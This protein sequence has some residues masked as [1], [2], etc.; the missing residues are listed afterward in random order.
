LTNPKKL[1]LDMDPGI[2]DAI[3]L[4]MVSCLEDVELLGVSTVAGNVD[5]VKTTR[6]AL[7]ILEFL[8]VRVG[9]FRGSSRPLIRPHENSAHVHGADGLGGVDL[10][11]PKTGP[12]PLPGPM[13]MSQFARSEP[14]KITVVATG[15]LT[16]VAI[17][18]ML[19]TE[20]PN[21]VRQLVIMGGAFSITPYGKGNV[22]QFSE[23]NIYADPEAA[24][25]VF[26]SFPDIV[27]VGLDVTTDPR[28][29][30]R[31]PD[32]ERLVTG[33][34]RGQLAARMMGFVV[35]RMGHFAPHD[36]LAVYCFYNPNIAKYVK[37]CVNVITT[38]DS[39]RGRTVFEIPKGS[40]KPSNVSVA[41]EVDAA[42]FKEEL[43]D[44]LQK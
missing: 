42:R 20:F 34:K 21:I 8:G 18:C 35:N 17:A 13:A 23:Y 36:P 26:S 16:N 19:D 1:F 14:G 4:M 41:S 24:N 37:G 10:P 3:A 11:E 33:S 5:V 6:N 43:L 25:I 38:N 28:L 9:V 2:D 40:S 31:Q 12:D 30:I 32:I 15:P 7:K 39:E 27:C 29:L 22:N 44:L